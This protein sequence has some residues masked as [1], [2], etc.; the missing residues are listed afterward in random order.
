MSE[1][2]TVVVNGETYI[3]QDDAKKANTPISGRSI[4]RCRNA[5][6]HVG[7]VKVREDG[8]LVLNNANRIWRW[9]GA[10]TLSEV[11][12]HGVN[13]RNAAVY[14]FDRIGRVRGYSGSR[15]C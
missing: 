5:G 3:H 2:R 15:G 9:R 4:V 1:Q 6:V 12:L 10:N 11:A 7:T 13:R 8:R 14:H